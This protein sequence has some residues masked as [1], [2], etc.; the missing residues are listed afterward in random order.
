[1]VTSLKIRLVIL[2]LLLSAIIP[3]AGKPYKGGE[4]RTAQ[5]YTYGKFEVRMKSAHASG[6]LASFFTYHDVWGYWN[7]IDIEIMGR[8]TNE[9][10]FNVISPGQ[11]NHVYRKN[12][13]FSPHADFHVYAFEWTPSY[14]AWYIDGV[15][16][17]I[18]VGS[19]VQQLTEP[20]KIMMNIWQPASVDWAGAWSD[21]VLPVYAYYDWVKYY[22]YQPDSA[23]SGNLF[24]LEWTENFD[25]WDQ[26]RWQK[27]T[28]TFDGNNCDFIQDNVVFV[29]GYMVLCLTDNVNTGYTGGPLSIAA[30]ND[31][32]HQVQLGAAFPNPFN[33]R[34]TIPFNCSE[35]MDLLI[36]IHD[37]K[38]QLV[39]T[40]SS[41]EFNA[42][43]H[44]IVWNG[45][46]ENVQP[47]ASGIYF[48]RLESERAIQSRKLLLIK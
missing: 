8:Y 35:N 46:A 15:Q 21:T 40:L 7:E 47:V 17:H 22:S 36:S 33:G 23:A 48:M 29:D 6:M 44:L 45:M 38:G 1:M 25:F 26:V 42:G 27:A 11:V 2:I 12:T 10:Q 13:S 39:K 16:A 34:V 9:V 31:V 30:D 41:T 18:Q 5:A 32:P 19:H 24:Q 20:Q 43:S 3:L 14:V 37:L 4:L 28:H